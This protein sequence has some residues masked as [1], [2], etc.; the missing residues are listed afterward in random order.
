MVSI[1]MGGY[2]LARLYCSSYE[3]LIN[4]FTTKT[5]YNIRINSIFIATDDLD[6]L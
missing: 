5:P 1:G 3:V 2:Y 6:V 4:F